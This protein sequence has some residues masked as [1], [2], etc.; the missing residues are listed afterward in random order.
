MF[1]RALL[2][3]LV[4][5]GLAAFALPPL[6]AAM[7]PWRGATILPGAFVMLLGL[8]V[9]LWCV[10]DF[11]IAGK[12][13]LAPWEPP[14]NLVIIGLYRFVRNPMYIGVLILVS[15]WALLFASPLL[16][17]YVFIVEVSFHIRVTVIEEPRLESHFG[18]QWQKYKSQVGRWLPKKLSPF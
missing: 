18:S 14:K 5:P 3:F 10:R 8:V 12:G 7:D 13:T 9:L 4:L 11:Y 16:A 15:G 2:A 1:L 17:C 6:I